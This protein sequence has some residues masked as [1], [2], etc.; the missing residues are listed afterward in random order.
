MIKTYITF[1]G[2]TALFAAPSLAQ[3]QSLTLRLEPGVAVP[4]T[5]PQAQ[6]FDVGGAFALKPEVGLG[7]YFSAGPMVQVIQLPSKVS[8]VEAGNAW[9]YGLFGR[10]K[11]PHNEK[12]TGRGWSAVS[13]WVDLDLKVVHTDPL[14]RFG[15]A[16]AVGASVPTS[17]SRWLW[18]GPFARY[19]IVNQ[20]DGK[21]SVNTNSAKTLI[22]GLSF[23]LGAT[24]DAK[25]EPKPVD[26]PK[27]SPPVEQ[28]KETPVPPTPPVV[29]QFKPRIQ[30]A[31]D[32]ATLDNTEI[33]LLKH[34][35]KAM[36]AD[37]SY[38]VNIS[39]HASSEGQ[40]EHNNKLAQKRA[41]SV[42]E[43]LVASGIDRSRMTAT[44]F[45]SRVPV[46]DNA[47]EDGRVVNRRVE[48][49]V[50]FSLVKGAK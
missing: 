8:G 32:S 23:E 22:F 41:D 45:G 2:A 39:G 16:V 21:A 5:D 49:D 17:D 46:A 15:A 40:V 11:R 3:A 18:V 7:S 33:V 48:F 30:F 14:D 29:V 27:Q 19:D 28:P 6:R 35:V 38:H 34:V 24:M 1:I 37:V 47:T 12:N 4:L 25:K 13:P 50:S 9:S 44:G 20:E 36:L 42:T 26:P 10:L 43:F 31:W